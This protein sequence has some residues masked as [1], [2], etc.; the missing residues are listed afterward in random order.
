MIEEWIGLVGGLEGRGENLEGSMME[1]EKRR[2]SVLS[3]GV[4]RNSLT[5][6]SY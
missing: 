1:K 2:T 4:T 5:L 6:R 3:G